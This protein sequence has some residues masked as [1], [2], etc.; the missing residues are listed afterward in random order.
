MRKIRTTPT[1]AEEAQPMCGIAGIWGDQGDIRRM[2]RLLEHRGPDDEGY[3]A[4]GP[5]QLG[6]RRLI[7]IDPHGGQQPIFNEDRTLALVFNGLIFN[8]RELRQ[9]LEARGHRFRSATD[10]EVI[11]HAYE[12]WGE[13]CLHHFN[14]MFA[15]AIHDGRRIWLARD[16]MGE[17]PLY[18][19]LV[20]RRLVFASEIKSI[21]ADAPSEP[22]FSEELLVLETTT[23]GRTMFRDIFAL[24]PGHVLSWDGEQLTT[25]RYWDLPSEVDQIRSEDDAVEELRWL[26]ED[27]VRIRL[28]SDVP[29]GAFLS[30]GLDSSLI[31]CLAKPDVV[32]S[33]RFPH[34]QTYDESRYA[35][36]VARHVGARHQVIEPSPGAF[37]SF[38][39]RI[40]HHLDQPAATASSI[41]EF[42]LAALASR[43][44]K[45]VL[46]G[47]GADKLFGGY[48]RYLLTLEEERLGQREELRN[49]HALAR[50]FWRPDIFGE[51]YQ[52]YH[53]MI[54]RGRPADNSTLE[55]VQQ[56]FSGRRSLVD[57][58]GACDIAISLPPLI[59]MND[60]AAS[61]FGLENRT[62]F[63][64]HRIVEFAFRL[65]PEMKIREMTTKYILRRAARGIVPD[66][67]IDRTDKLGLVVPIAAWFTGE[68]SQWAGELDQSFGRR[69]VSGLL[70]PPSRSRGEFDRALYNRISMELWLRQVLDGQSVP[71]LGR[72]SAE[73]LIAACA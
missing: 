27:A 43:Q 10:S 26:I 56:L 57:K 65:P 44:V 34:G 63:L 18:Y 59:T 51:P 47:Q 52:R 13:D 29:L 70:R 67:V 21:L 38:Y 15:F 54:R 11:I 25:S 9:E 64:D 60:R 6:S 50:W 41:A 66:E 3:Y 8:Y 31:T 22:V 69:Q 30:G 46:G 58:M 40:I 17:K 42:S 5:V 48:V 16:R 2:T 62:P 37:R 39:P 73:E 20:G 45:V 33:C 14:G 12:E 71:A 49:Y 68:L 19:R 4:S 1:T 61:A 28:R 35:A 36:L 24:R 23:G 53:Q 72:D 55:M 32:F 7:V